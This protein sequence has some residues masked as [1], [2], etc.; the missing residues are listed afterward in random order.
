M[1]AEC[2]HVLLREGSSGG[3]LD[4]YVAFK[5]MGITRKTKSWGGGHGTGNARARF[6][7]EQGLYAHSQ[8]T[9][10]PIYQNPARTRQVAE[11]R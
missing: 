2:G 1:W 11:R 10:I 4:T 3:L 8:V 5:S 6:F 9:S 7:V